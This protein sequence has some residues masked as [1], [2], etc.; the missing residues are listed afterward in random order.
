MPQ[1][2]HLC[3]S[4]EI[5]PIEIQLLILTTISKVSS[6]SALVHASPTF[7]RA[8]RAYRQEV[9]S[10]VLCNQNTQGGGTLLDPIAAL[11]S[12]P[13]YP[14]RYNSDR[15]AVG[16]FLD[17]YKH[18]TFGYQEMKELCLDDCFALL[19]LERM[20]D[21]LSYDFCR[22]AVLAWSECKGESDPDDAFQPSLTERRRLK[23][24]LY[25]W[26]IHHN[27]FGTATAGEYP[28]DDDVASDVS[29]GHSGEEAAALFLLLFPPWEIEEI[30]SLVNYSFERYRKLITGK[31][32]RKYF[33]VPHEMKDAMM[34]SA[35]PETASYPMEGYCN[36]FL[37][38]GPS[39]FYEILSTSNPHERRALLIQHADEYGLESL[40]LPPPWPSQTD[41]FEPQDPEDKDQELQGLQFR[42]DVSPMSPNAG[43]VWLHGPASQHKHGDEKNKKLRMLG[44]VI[45][46]QERL[47]SGGMF[48][49]GL[50]NSPNKLDKKCRVINPPD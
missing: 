40:E 39:F 8:Y 50:C 11:R 6:L 34:K 41:Q 31:E 32:L 7:H 38:L 44:Y 12:A 10:Q 30:A 22:W 9:L 14:R 15:E 35:R 45:W 37:S 18:G 17:R 24:A 46:D 29:D 16:L 4:L 3:G 28:E 5:L 1:V 27:L 47:C 43:W 25:R 19:K 23:R 42:G 33:V 2:S 20:V 21:Y 13:L 48:D 26:Q 49:L 36:H